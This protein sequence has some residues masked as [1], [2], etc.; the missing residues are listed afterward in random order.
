MDNDTHSTLSL[1]CP[2]LASASYF[3][4]P[5]AST[6][7]GTTSVDVPYNMHGMCA[8]DYKKTGKQYV[9][10]LAEGLPIFNGYCGIGT[11]GNAPPSPKSLIINKH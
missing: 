11:S 4:L 6:C 9:T 7:S 8:N 5:V 10:L 1:L 2:T 3:T